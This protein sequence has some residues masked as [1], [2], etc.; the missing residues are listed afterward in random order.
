[1]SEF[2]KTR[3]PDSEKIKLDTRKRVLVEDFLPIIYRLTDASMYLSTLEIRDHMGVVIKF[4]SEI[5]NTRKEVEEWQARIQE[6]K[7]YRK[8]RFLAHK[9]KYKPFDPGPYY[10][11]YSFFHNR[12]LLSKY[13]PVIEQANAVLKILRKLEMALAF[14]NLLKA[15]IRLM[16][17]HT[18]LKEWNVRM[19]EIRVLYNFSRKTK[20]RLSEQA[21][22][23][24]I[25]GIIPYNRGPQQ[26]DP[27]HYIEEP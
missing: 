21:R 19:N 25:D 16:D 7:R 1:M 12:E 14:E 10:A 23:I 6:L 18:M 27:S 22:M 9:L 2:D 17:L 5:N 20:L 4:K 3:I 26:F 8:V 24:R 13:T 15:Q 11:Q